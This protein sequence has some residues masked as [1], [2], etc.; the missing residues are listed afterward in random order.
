M[1]A[2]NGTQTKRQGVAFD[3][4]IPDDGPELFM[5]R[6]KGNKCLT[7][8]IWGTKVRGVWYHWHGGS[9]EPHYHDPEVCPGCK[10]NQ[11]KK[12]KGY[13]HCYCSEMRQEVFLELTR[14][15][16]KSLCQQLQGVAALRGAV[17]QVKR[18]AS[19]SGRLYVS[20]LN[21]CAKPELLPPE[22]DPRLSI[23]RLWGL[24]EEEIDRWLNPQNDPD[25]RGEFQ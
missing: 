24:S 21:P 16:A 25:A 15:C 5:L 6:M 9:S 23:L 13:I 11:G 2:S 1:S 7:F 10:A 12:W 18:T 19:D 22:K 20:I 3:D 17:I 14:N 4:S 8:T